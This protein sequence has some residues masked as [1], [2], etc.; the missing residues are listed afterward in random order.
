MRV[1]HRDYGKVGVTYNV[2][3]LSVESINFIAVYKTFFFLFEKKRMSR[4][5][6]MRYNPCH[7]I[8]HSNRSTNARC[9]HVLIENRDK[10]YYEIHTHTHIHT[11]AY[12]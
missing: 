12:T 9:V 1:Y 3:F 2:S 7:N 4:G 10:Y 6:T 11:H 8:F 5:G